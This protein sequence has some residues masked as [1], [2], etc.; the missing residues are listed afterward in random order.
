MTSR[1]SFILRVVAELLAGLLAAGAFGLASHSPNGSFFI[2]IGVGLLLVAG[3]AGYLEPSA[4]KVWLHPI[5]IM[6]PELM[7]LPAA[8][9]TC[10]GFECAGVIA[11][12]ALAGLFALVL[13]GVSFAAFFARRKTTRRILK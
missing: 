13:M 12:L 3:L 1:G 10:H 11:F 2:A 9:L 7:A 4:K 8:V 5:L 6:W